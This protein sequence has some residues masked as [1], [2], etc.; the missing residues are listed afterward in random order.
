[1]KTTQ[2]KVG[3]KTLKSHPAG[4]SAQQN[5]YISMEVVGEISL[6]DALQAPALCPVP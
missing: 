1:M 5:T 3:S 2:C 6:E 4:R